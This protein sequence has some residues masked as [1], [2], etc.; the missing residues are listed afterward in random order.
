MSKQ[1]YWL[2]LKTDLWLFS[3]L[4]YIPIIVHSQDIMFKQD[5]N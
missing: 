5:L 1:T 4:E 2:E 3:S